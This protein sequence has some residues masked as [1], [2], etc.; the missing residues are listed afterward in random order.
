MVSL[1][2]RTVKEKEDFIEKCAKI[3]LMNTLRS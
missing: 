2:F 3:E 1:K